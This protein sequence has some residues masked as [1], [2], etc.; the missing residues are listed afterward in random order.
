MT[1]KNLKL[2]QSGKSKWNSTQRF[3]KYYTKRE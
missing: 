1:N 3:S 2:D